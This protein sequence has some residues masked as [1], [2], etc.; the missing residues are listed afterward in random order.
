MDPSLH[1]KNCR[2]HERESG[3]LKSG[4]TEDATSRVIKS[5]QKK[6]FPDEYTAL[7]PNTSFALLVR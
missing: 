5:A 2:F 6:A 7:Q 4:D 3:E 1:E